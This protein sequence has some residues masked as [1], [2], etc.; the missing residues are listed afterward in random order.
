MHHLIEKQNDPSFIKLLRAASHAY[1]R[2][3]LF[4][5]VFLRLMFGIA[6]CVPVVY[7]YQNTVTAKLAFG[8]TAFLMTIFIQL[9]SVFIK[10]NVS[11]GALIKEKFDTDLFG[12]TWKPT[13]AKPDQLEIEK[14]SLGYGG[15]KLVDWYPVNFNS[16]LPDSVVI[17]ACQ[18]INAEWDVWIRMSF[19]RFLYIVM[20]GFSL[21]LLMAILYFNADGVSILP[22]L[23]SSLSFYLYFI[24]QVRGHKAIIETRKNISAIIDKYITQE[25]KEPSVE[26]LRDI[27]DDILST[28]KMTIIV[29]NFYYKFFHKK[30]NEAI[31][32]YVEDVNSHWA[33][34]R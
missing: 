13:V 25:R 5:V 29:P 11:K 31:N 28:R 27:Q 21:I 2:A 17:A 33:D 32:L 9:I 14:L 22:L 18:R 34:N 7:L 19:C 26:L 1:T 3:K 20:T 4:E 24:N 30:I 10:S 6:M 16:D 8:L 23:F 15:R 12:L